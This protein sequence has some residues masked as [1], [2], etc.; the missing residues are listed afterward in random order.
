[1]FL[2][3]FKQKTADE[4]RISD[5]SSDVCSSDLGAQD[6][7]RAGHG[8]QQDDGMAARDHKAGKSKLG[9]GRPDRGRQE[10]DKEQSGVDTHFGNAESALRSGAVRRLRPPAPYGLDDEGIGLAVAG[11][12][13]TQRTMWFAGRPLETTKRKNRR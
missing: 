9:L 2:F 10:S 11:T 13:L 8:D 6:V 4:M 5:W 3:F 7:A 12:C 1:M